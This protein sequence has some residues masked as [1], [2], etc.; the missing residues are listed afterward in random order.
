MLTHQPETE[1]ELGV[2]ITLGDQ[3]SYARFSS[4]PPH[5]HGCRGINARQVTVLWYP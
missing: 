3:L 2:E 1:N 4:L 5:P